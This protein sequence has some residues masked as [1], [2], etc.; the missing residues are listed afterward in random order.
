MPGRDLRDGVHSS[1][2]FTRPSHWL[3]AGFSRF[4]SVSQTHQVCFFLKA[5]ARY[6]LFCVRDGREG[7]LAAFPPPY[8]P[9][10]SPK[11]TPTRV[12]LLYKCSLKTRNEFPGLSLPTILL[13]GSLGLF[14]FKPWLKCRLFRG[15]FLDPL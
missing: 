10:A 3:G 1:C 8:F 12:G 2:V 7:D 9:L 6:G 14:L 15:T 4:L 11:A 13:P 5:A